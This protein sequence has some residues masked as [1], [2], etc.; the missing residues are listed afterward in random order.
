MGRVGLLSVCDA[1]IQGKRAAD[2]MRLQPELGSNRFR[3][4]TEPTEAWDASH[5]QRGGVGR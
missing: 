1:P 2:I 3:P 5:K 4:A